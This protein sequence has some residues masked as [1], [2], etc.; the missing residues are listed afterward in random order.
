MGRVMDSDSDIEETAVSTDNIEIRACD[1]AILRWIEPC[2]DL[3]PA[4][5]KLNVMDKLGEIG[6]HRKTSN[7]TCIELDEYR[8]KNLSEATNENHPIDSMDI[9]DGS[10]SPSYSDR[11]LTNRIDSSSVDQVIENGGDITLRVFLAKAEG[12]DEGSSPDLQELGFTAGQYFLNHSTFPPITKTNK[13]AIQFE[14][15]LSFDTA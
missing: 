7:T 14:G 10:T 4:R 11:S 6:E 1:V 8:V 12:N 3:L 9:G 5:G 15:T 2:W 13:K